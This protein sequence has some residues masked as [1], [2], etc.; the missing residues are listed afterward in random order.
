[1]VDFAKVKSHDQIVDCEKCQKTY[2]DLVNLA[3][4]IDELLGDRPVGVSMFCLAYALQAGLKY[5]KKSGVESPKLDITVELLDDLQSDLVSAFI[6][7]NHDGS[8]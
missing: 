7:A 4:E 3:K 2:E 6:K 5:A 8:E 1:M